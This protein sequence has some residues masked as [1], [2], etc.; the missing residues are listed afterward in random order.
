VCG[1]PIER[2]VQAQR[3]TFACPTCQNMRFLR[4]L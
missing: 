4:K 2:F 1:N 3:A